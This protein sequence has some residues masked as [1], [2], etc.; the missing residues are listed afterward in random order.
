MSV[1]FSI[2]SLPTGEFTIG[3]YDAEK[4]ADV[5]VARAD[6]YE[7]ILVERAAHMLVCDECSAYGCYSR[8]VMD[9]SDDLDVNVANTNARMLLV[10]LGLNEG[11]D[12]D[13][14]GTV[15]GE[16]FLGAVLLAMASDR[17]DTGVAPAVIGGREVGQSG[18]TMVDCGLRP[19]YFADR[20]GALHA[21]ATE[22]VRLGRAVTFA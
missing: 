15:D 18:A 22:A 8:P 12:G 13:L 9:V 6:S 14:C 11:E 4:G 2:E 5:E 3:C 21:L 20:F 17:D 10:A 1:T 19:G 7:A 16:Q